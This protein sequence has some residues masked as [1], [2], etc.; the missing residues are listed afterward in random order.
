MNEEND[1]VQ[2]YREGLKELS[3]INNF[4]FTLPNSGKTTC[5]ISHIS[6]YISKSDQYAINCEALVFTITMPPKKTEVI[7]YDKNGQRKT[8]TVNN[9]VWETVFDFQ[10]Q[11]ANFL[12]FLLI[13]K[14]I[15]FKTRKGDVF[16]NKVLFQPFD[17]ITSIHQESFED[18][19]KLKWPVYQSLKFKKVLDWSKKHDL[20]FDNIARTKLGIALNAYSYLFE[21][22]TSYTLDL[23]WSLIGIEAVYCSSKDG[24]SEQIFERSQLV[25]GPI[26]DF[27]KRLKSMYNFRSRFIHGDLMIPSSIAKSFATE[28][29]ENFSEEFYQASILAVAILT[30]TLQKIV[31]MDK[32]ELG[33]KTVIV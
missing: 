14:P 5:K 4:S 19:Q 1:V 2:E 3:E 22:N 17:E 26:I 28:E 7:V 29:V 6:Q 20:S 9:F 24:I 21:H 12:L 33:F 30:A 16:V 31:E 13:A 10:T 23:L 11:V 32:S 18:I 25:L 27:K 15:A 8:N